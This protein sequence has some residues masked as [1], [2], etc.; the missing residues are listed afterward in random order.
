MGDKAKGDS[1]AAPAFAPSLWKRKSFF[2]P[3]ELRP[4]RARG[5]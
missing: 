2:T 3:G 4:R 5:A 1:A